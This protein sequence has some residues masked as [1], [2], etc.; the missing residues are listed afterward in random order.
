MAPRAPSYAPAPLPTATAVPRQAEE[1][2]G[3]EGFCEQP[4][5]CVW[6]GQRETRGLS[7]CWASKVS[8]AGPQRAALRMTHA[9]CQEALASIPLPS[10]FSWHQY[11]PVSLPLSHLC[12][13]PSFLGARSKLGPGRR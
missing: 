10:G 12:S 8:P 7:C 1:G 6:W 13:P 2:S 11:C 4:Q 3:R 5:L 9:W